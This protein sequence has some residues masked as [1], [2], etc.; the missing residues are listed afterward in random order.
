MVNELTV[1]T[2]IH[3]LAAAIWV[4]GGYVLSV[5]MAMA[6][7]SGAPA[8]MLN[9][10]RLSHFVGTR[11]FVPMTLVVLATGAWLAEEYFDWGL[12]W[13]QLGLI[14]LAGALAVGVFYLTPRASRAI[15]GL[16]AGSPPPPGRNWVPIVARLNLLLIST[17]LVLMVI[18]PT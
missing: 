13:I 4:G 2:S 11:I 1:L 18:K 10:M 3:V 6:G 8:T 16:E 12:L 17:V 9:A 7:R 15:A 5:A 14:G